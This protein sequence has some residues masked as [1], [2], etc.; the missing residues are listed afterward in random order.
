ME[1]K[2]HSLER[3][4]A[5]LDALNPRAVLTRGYT[6]TMDPQGKPVTSVDSLRKGDTLKTCLADGIITST[7]DE[8]KKGEA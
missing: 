5:K 7:I 2:K 1:G 3:A 4:K 8:V 6:M